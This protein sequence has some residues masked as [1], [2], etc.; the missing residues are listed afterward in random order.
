MN[1]E[2][3]FHTIRLWTIGGSYKRT[4]YLKKNNV[5][6][7]IGN[8]CSIMDRRVPLYP[9]LIFLGDNVHIASRVEF[10]THDII[11]VVLNGMLEE[12]NF[13][14]NI[15]CI[16]IENNVFIGTGSIILGDVKIG[17]N[18]IVAAGSVVAKDIPSNSVVGGNPARVICSFEEYVQKRRIKEKDNMWFET[19]RIENQNVSEELKDFLSDYFDKKRSK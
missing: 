3:L 7:S 8:N 2:R 5:Y 18:V 4:E 14:E 11:H 19:Y 10:I 12:K 9:N 15:G 16:K 6:G 13:H 17:S 1:K